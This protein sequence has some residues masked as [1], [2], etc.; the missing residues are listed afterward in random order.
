MATN[1]TLQPDQA[2]ELV[3]PTHRAERNWRADISG[4]Q[5][6][7]AWAVAACLGAISISAAPPNTLIRLILP[8]VVMFVYVWRTYPRESSASVGLR[9]TRIAQ[10]ADSAYFLGFLWTLWAL[11]DS[12]VLKGATSSQT[13]FRVFGYAL[14]TTAAGMAIRLYLL[15][16]KYGAVD[17]TGE[18][19]L[20]VER[21]LQ[22]FSESMQSAS[23]SVQSF[24]KSAEA[25]NQGVNKL[26]TAIESLDRQFADTH[27]QT[28]KTIKDNIT[29]T[30]ED[31]R[32]ALK[33]PAQEYGRAIRAFTA[34]VDQQSQLFIDVLQKSSGNLNQAIKD[35]TETAHTIIRTTGEQ[36][37]SDHLDLADRLRSQAARILEELHNLSTRMASLDIPPE[38]LKKIVDS[39][40]QLERALLAV[41]GL[42]R[43]DGQLRANLVRFGEEVQLQ[44]EAV[45]K[46]LTSL[47]IRINSIKVPPEAV[48]DISELTRSIGELQTSVE[49]L[50]QKSSDQRWQT[51][52]QGASDAI[53]KLTMAVTNLRQ[54]V[55]NTDE[56]IKK[57]VSA[58][59][60]RR[61]RRRF[62]RN[63]LP[64]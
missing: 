12:F 30:V 61:S 47:T 52:P 51:A 43:P 35:A 9:G 53:L 3:P 2:P 36:I 25:L 50:L 4:E 33:G 31:I 40:N 48:I 63:L 39:F 54:T 60:G 20:T 13:A 23:Q 10:L 11:I 37:A 7:F 59:D 29:V 32:A 56:A 14:V 28:T 15:Q 58:P 19:E 57:N 46:A 62:P 17:Q 34:N 16:F 6:A 45:A 44:T 26:S 18:A 8:V 41:A 42:L 38:G 1:P 64:W 5:P 27:Q 21:N 55:S 22:Q 24:H 49:A